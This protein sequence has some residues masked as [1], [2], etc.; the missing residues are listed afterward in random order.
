MDL[1]TN[2]II[3]SRNVIF[4][5]STFPA[6]EKQT[7]NTSPY[8]FL[9]CSDP[10]SPL[11]QSILTNQTL[12]S[13]TNNTVVTS[14]AASNTTPPIF[15]PSPNH[16]PPQRAA[17]PPARMT[18]RGQAGIV[19][20]KKI[21][22]LY[23]SSVSR[24]PTSPQKALLDPNWNPSMTEEYDA[25]IRNKT[26]RLVPRPAN[27]NVINSMWLYKH[28]YGA[29]GE[30]KR[31][32]SRLVANGKTQEEGVDYDETFSPV[33]KP[34][35]RRAV[36]DVA[37]NRGWEVKQLD[38]KNAFLHG[39]I[40]EDIYMHQPPGFV[41][42]KHPH[43]V[44]KLEKA[45]YGLKQAPRAWNARFSQYL[46]KLGFVTTRSDASLFAYAHNG[47][48]AYLLLYVDDI[49]LTGSSKGLL[50]RIT[51]DLKTEFPMSDMGSLKFFLGIKVDY[52][53]SGIFLSQQ[54]YATD[55][56]QRAG[57][58]D[59]KPISTP[60]DVNSKLA[61]DNGPRVDNPT[62]YHSLAGALQY[63]T[64]TRP[65]IAYAVQ[66]VCLF[67]HDPRQVHLT[68]LKRIIRYVQGTKDHGLQM[69][70]SSISNLTAYSDADW[71][72]CPDTRRSTSGY[73]V[74]LGDNLISWSSKRQ[75]TVSRSS[76]EAEYRG[77][78]NTVAET[79]WIRNLL[80]ELRQPISK[81]TLI[82]CDNISLVY[83][84]SN[85]VKHQRTKHVELDIHFVREKVALGQVKVLHVPSAYQYTDIFT[86]GLPS[87]L[88]N[89]FR[90]SLTVKRFN[91]S[92]ARG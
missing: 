4:D 81:A 24:L 73:C 21:F 83:L 75:P 20:P 52:N 79:C 78:A 71:A 46:L 50:D 2:R 3:I 51:S 76:A 8:K 55:I 89:D 85:P 65:D 69:Y 17:P 91:A 13:A 38:V 1:K 30:H 63:L 92:T 22:T 25:Q 70:K 10:P 23:T 31:H 87:S 18:T 45:L 19:K 86:K 28:K 6:A 56:I 90:N 88:F 39:T 35:T 41:D 14:A 9:D 37:L 42:K 47:E 64:F 40:S 84:S 62:H 32:K 77:V 43:Y 58:V 16:S 26:W 57:M 5:E 34:A 48:L 68:A 27:A 12:P 74:Y 54:Q 44:C 61:A 72:G 67:M 80:L 53:K 15:P 11:F 60:A 36:L 29:D 82:F 33:V 66:Q 49:I 59:C 7:S